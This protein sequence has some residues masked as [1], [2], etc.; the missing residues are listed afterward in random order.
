MPEITR[1]YGIVIQMYLKPLEHEP[2]HIH[3]IYGEFKGAFDIITGKMTKGNL[4][5]K[6]QKLVTEWIIKYAE[7]LEKMWDKQI[8]HKLPPLL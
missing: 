1:F 3:A 7:D 5:K 2:K 6:A 8:V 4:P